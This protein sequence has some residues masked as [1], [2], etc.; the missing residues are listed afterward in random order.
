M[1]VKM[2][3]ISL[4]E[5]WLARRIRETNAWHVTLSLFLSL[6]SLI[7]S[8]AARIRLFEDWHTVTLVRVFYPGARS[9]NYIFAN[10]LVHLAEDARFRE[11]NVP[12][13]GARGWRPPL[14]LG[15]LLGPCTKEISRRVVEIT[16]RILLA[17]A[18]CYAYLN[19]YL[20]GVA[21]ARIHRAWRKRD[22]FMHFARDNCTSA[23][24]RSSFAL[25]EETRLL[26]FQRW[27]TALHSLFVSVSAR[28]FATSA[29]AAGC[30]RSR[31]R[32]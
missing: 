17:F 20:S 21:G 24:I 2:E 22:E 15:P 5:T 13:T 10:A 11:I 32:S 1:I 29:S 18:S 23:G 28:R 25:P 12:L 26:F 9:H 19:I 8:R 4:N 3:I 7:N 14:P 30:P 31:H 16:A 27:K 6:F